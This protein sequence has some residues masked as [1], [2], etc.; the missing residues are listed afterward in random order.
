MF[1]KISK[2]Q[3]HLRLPLKLSV[4]L[5]LKSLFSSL[6]IDEISDSHAIEIKSIKMA[7]RKSSKRSLTEILHVR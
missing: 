6:R 5:I 1:S 4:Q 7:T 2:S 3:V